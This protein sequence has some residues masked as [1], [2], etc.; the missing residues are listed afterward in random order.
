MREG[1]SW[2]VGLH[3]WEVRWKIFLL[4]HDTNILYYSH[5]TLSL[6]STCGWGKHT[7]AIRKKIMSLMAQIA[8]LWKL[9]WNSSQRGNL[10]LAEWGGEHQGL[11]FW[12]SCSEQDADPLVTQ[13]NV[14]YWEEDLE[15]TG[16]DSAHMWDSMLFSAPVRSF[17]RET[18]FSWNQYWFW[19][20]D[21]CT[22]GRFSDRVK[23]SNVKKKM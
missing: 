4:S 9:H 14:V 13:S 12:A 19:S 11:E 16:R 18:V 20:R 6:E 1:C 21:I 7:Y 15:T 5:F 22:N 2:R 23:K 10:F 17:A 8:L 3:R